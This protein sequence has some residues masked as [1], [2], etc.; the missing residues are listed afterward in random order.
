MYR[1]ARLATSAIGIAGLAFA[2]LG[3]TGTGAA[4]AKVNTC[5]LTVN[6]VQALELQDNDGRDESFLKLGGTATANKTYTDNQ[7]RHNIGDKDFQ[8]SV[9][10]KVFERDTNNLTL[11]D[12]AS[13]PCANDSGQ[14]DVSGAGAIYRVTWNVLVIP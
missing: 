9:G 2:T 6:S 10:V 3:V 11:I 12:S 14:S 5:R 13:I 7:T 8:G 1:T 4:S